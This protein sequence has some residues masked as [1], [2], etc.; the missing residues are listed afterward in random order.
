MRRTERRAVSTALALA[1]TALGVTCLAAAA[2]ATVPAPAQAPTQGGL[3]RV[4]HISPSTGAIDMYAEGPGL[5]LTRVAAS[6]AYRGLG[7]ARRPGRRGA[8]RESRGGARVGAD[9][10]LRRGGGSRAAARGAP[11]GSV[12]SPGSPSRPSRPLPPRCR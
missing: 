9:R 1:T 2:P 5:P 7:A 11:P 6:V 8:Q 3:L 4:A 10:G 12:R